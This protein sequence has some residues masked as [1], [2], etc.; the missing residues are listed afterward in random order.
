V[1]EQQALEKWRSMNP[2][3]APLPLRHSADAARVISIAAPLYYTQLIFRSVSSNTI[4]TLRES[5]AMK[6]DAV[7][8]GEYVKGNRSENGST[9]RQP[10][11]GHT[12]SWSPHFGHRSKRYG[13]EAHLLEKDHWCSQSLK[14]GAYV[15]SWCRSSC[16]SGVLRR[17]TADSKTDS[18]PVEFERTKS[19]NLKQESGLQALLPRSKGV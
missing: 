7:I 13:T 16:F 17:A 5:L 10:G 15:T 11:R 3:R 8:S 18:Y 4:S 12:I 9:Q 6:K 19:N 2:T 14:H 1:S